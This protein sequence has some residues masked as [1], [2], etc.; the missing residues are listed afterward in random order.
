MKKR[1]T[2]R[3]AEVSKNNENEPHS[4][5]GTADKTPTSDCAAR[6]V[7]PVENSCVLNPDKSVVI[8]GDSNPKENI[9]DEPT[10]NILDHPVRNKRH[11]TTDKRFPSCVE[12]PKKAKKRATTKGKSSN[13]TNGCKNISAEVCVYLSTHIARHFFIILSINE[14]M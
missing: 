4:L 10:Y 11:R 14:V 7:S 3:R 12:K 8:P 2:D 9:S 6:N 5:V 1:L 13:A